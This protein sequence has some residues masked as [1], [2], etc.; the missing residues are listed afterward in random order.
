MTNHLDYLGHLTTESARF[1]E[2]LRGLPA[3]AAVPACPD[4]TADDLLW[5]LGSVQWFWGTVV[6]EKLTGPQAEEIKPPRPTDRAG[7]PAFFEAASRELARVLAAGQPQDPAWTWFADQTVGFIQRKQAHEALIHRIDAEET[8][9]LRTGMDPQLSADGVDEALRVMYGALPHWGSFTPEAGRLLRL[10]AT[11]TGDT[12]LV[13]L[14]RFTGTD[15]GGT[16]YNELD[17]QVDDGDPDRPAAA[18]ISA[19]AADLDC[20]LWHRTPLGEVELAGAEDVL[21]DFQSVIAPG[22]S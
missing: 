21:R 1:S 4:W 3:D 13:A 6:R 9:G 12:W 5:H 16:S 14:G 18:S 2:A 8:A 20:R 19:S 15:P 17:I 7:L 10:R 22:L 11:D